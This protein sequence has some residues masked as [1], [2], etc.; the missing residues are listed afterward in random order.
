MLKW[1]IYK[2]VTASCFIITDSVLGMKKKDRE[3]SLTGNALFFFYTIRTFLIF[4]FY[5]FFLCLKFKDIYSFGRNA[6]I[7]I[8]HIFNLKIV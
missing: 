6:V 1:F 8:C 3:I 4:L 5:G 7:D 2:S